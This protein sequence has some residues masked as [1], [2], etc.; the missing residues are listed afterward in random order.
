[1]P[2]EPQGGAVVRLN[3]RARVAVSSA[4]VRRA[5]RRAIAGDR[6]WQERLARYEDGDV[7][8][9]ELTAVAVIERPDDECSRPLACCHET[10]WLD[11]HSARDNVKERLR[12]IAARDFKTVGDG[13]RDHHGVAIEGTITV[14]LELEAD[15]AAR[16]APR[17]AGDPGA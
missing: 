15:L 9:A 7:V 11:R 5:R 14:D 8:L 10:V 4:E 13:L 1:M 3:A 6:A 2:G 12:K 17:A 16:F